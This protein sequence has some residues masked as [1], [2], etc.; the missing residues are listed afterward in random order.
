MSPGGSDLARLWTGVMDVALEGAH[1]VVELLTS[2][3][4]QEAKHMTVT[5]SVSG[6]QEDWLPLSLALAGVEELGADTAGDRTSV[7]RGSSPSNLA[8][9]L[10]P[11]AAPHSPSRGVGTP[12]TPPLTPTGT[13]RRSS[14]VAAETSGSSTGSGKRGL[15]YKFAV[16]RPHATLGGQVASGAAPEGTTISE[17]QS[18]CSNI[19]ELSCTLLCRFCQAMRSATPAKQHTSPGAAVLHGL[20]S[21]LQELAESSQ[22]GTIGLN[23]ENLDYLQELAAA[24]KGA[25][26]FGVGETDGFQQSGFQPNP[27]FDGDA[28]V[29][30]EV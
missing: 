20:L 14:A 24:L 8:L 9:G 19:L 26:N 30:G 23:R 28:W 21:L 25:A 18:L 1:K 29:L 10:T 5:S 7:G 6:G 2:L 13:K 16:R 17:L 12:G 4:G 27:A 3:H 11:L 22:Q 15:R